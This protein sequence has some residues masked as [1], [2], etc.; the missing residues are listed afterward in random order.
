MDVQPCDISVA[1][2]N[3]GAVNAAAKCSVNVETRVERR[4]ASWSLSDVLVIPGAPYN[5]FSGTAAMARGVDIEGSSSSKKILLRMAGEVVG[6]ATTRNGQ[7]VLKTVWQVPEEGIRCQAKGAVSGRKVPVMFLSCD[8]AELWHR[9]LGYLSYDAM[10]KMVCEGAVTGKH[11][12]EAEVRANM[13]G[14]YV[15]VH[16]RSQSR[17]RGRLCNVCTQI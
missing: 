12:T 14:T 6:V 4:Q 3:G 5:V 1:V 17:E 7:A 11:V 8:K 9:R 10:L 2:A 16:T 13:M 15:M